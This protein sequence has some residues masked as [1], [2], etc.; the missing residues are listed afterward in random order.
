MVVGALTTR[1]GA[2]RVYVYEDHTASIAEVIGQVTR[3]V[4]GRAPM[5]RIADELAARGYSGDELDPD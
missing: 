5:Y 2:L 3:S 1:D 4:V